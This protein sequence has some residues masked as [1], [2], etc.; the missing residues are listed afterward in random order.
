MKAAA[1]SSSS[2]GGASN[3][4]PATASSASPPS[5]CC[6]DADDPSAD[7]G[8]EPLAGGLDHSGHVHAQGERRLG[9]HRGD[10]ASAAG[11]V[12]EVE[13]AGRHPHQRSPGAGLRRVDLADLDDVLGLTEPIDPHCPHGSRTVLRGLFSGQRSDADRRCRDHAV[14]VCTRLATNR[15]AGSCGCRGRFR[16]RPA[17]QRPADVGGHR[18][19]RSSR[20][21]SSMAGIRSASSAKTSYPRGCRSAP[22]TSSL[23]VVVLLDQ[24]PRIGGTSRPRHPVSA[25][26]STGQQ[27][28]VPLACSSLAVLRL[29]LGDRVAYARAWGD[30]CSSASACATCRVAK[31]VVDGV[32][33]AG[34]VAQVA[35]A[36]SRSDGG[37][38]GCSV[39]DVAG[40][41][42]AEVDR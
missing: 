33:V 9:R 31:R 35:R 17:G 25:S 39:D 8:L 14:A 20:S 32:P 10:P 41:R 42:T 38:R 26:S 13:R 37:P 30:G 15:S 22:A 3:T 36:G 40:D 4:L 34:A 27:R 24:L 6:G 19:N 18:A 29:V 2:S 5:D 12:T 23:S 16:L 7:P 1:S 28:L 21:A 11:D